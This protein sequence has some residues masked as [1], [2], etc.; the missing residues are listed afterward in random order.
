[1]LSYVT[2]NPDVLLRLAASKWSVKLLTL[3]RNINLFV[4]QQSTTTRKKCVSS[5][6]LK[7]FELH[8]ILSSLCSFVCDFIKN[9]FYLLYNMSVCPSVCP[10]KEINEK[11]ERMTNVLLNGVLTQMFIESCI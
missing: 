11:G 4:F 1:M 3:L 2:L 8:S 5:L 7:E 10:V 6:N 9:S